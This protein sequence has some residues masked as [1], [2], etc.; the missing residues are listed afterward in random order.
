MVFPYLK[1]WPGVSIHIKI[2]LDVDMIF[3]VNAVILCWKG[4]IYIFVNDEF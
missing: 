2:K 3:L 4:S 1:T